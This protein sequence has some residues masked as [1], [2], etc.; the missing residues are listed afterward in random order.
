[1]KYSNNVLFYG[2][3]LTFILYCIEKM[4]GRIH[5][6]CTNVDCAGS[7]YRIDI[8]GLIWN[9]W[10]IFTVYILWTRAY[11]VVSQKAEESFF[12]NYFIT[13]TKHVNK[14]STNLKYVY[15][16]VKKMNSNHWKYSYHNSL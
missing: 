7:K 2:F 10:D 15:K 13:P 12:Y 8:L 9:H 16:Q 5:K 14:Y 3:W 1:M 6:N 11:S 4:M